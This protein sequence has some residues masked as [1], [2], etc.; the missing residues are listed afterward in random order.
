M[1]LLLWLWPESQLHYDGLVERKH[2]KKVRPHA[3]S[4][5]IPL[6]KTVPSAVVLSIR[7]IKKVKP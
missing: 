1:A 2:C 4:T 7:G 3:K 5:S 6:D